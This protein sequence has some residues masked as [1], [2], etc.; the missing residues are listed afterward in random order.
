MQNVPATSLVCN[1]H[2][3]FDLSKH[4]Y[5]HLAA[6]TYKTKYDRQ[7]F[8]ARRAIMEQGF[9]DPLYE[10]LSE[11]ILHTTEP[12]ES[13]MYVLDA[14]CGEG[15]HLTQ[16]RKRVMQTSEASFIGVGVDLAKEGVMLAAKND[17]EVVWC[18]G[19]LTKAPFA[20]RQFHSILNLLSPCHSRGQLFARA[21]RSLVSR[22]TQNKIC[23]SSYDRALQSQLPANRQG[24]GSV[25]VPTG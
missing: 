24:T 3:C 20:D 19:D 21:T 12:E 2:H 13:R 25:S 14:G 18:V 4:G 22:V 23:E 7:L 1:N 6:R 11:V 10:V 16:V 9:F 17:P 15:Y 8:A 5:V